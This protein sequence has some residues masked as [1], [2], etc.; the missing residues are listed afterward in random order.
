MF[1]RAF[2]VALDRKSRLL[3]Q[4]IGGGVLPGKGHASVHAISRIHAL[5]PRK[6]AAAAPVGSN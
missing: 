1:H 5:M 6:S 4:A 3:A 2:Q